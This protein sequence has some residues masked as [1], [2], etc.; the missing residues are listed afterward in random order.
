MKTIHFSMEII[1]N[2]TYLDSL[3]FSD[4]TLECISPYNMQYFLLDS[5]KEHYRLLK[6][7]GSH[8]NFGISD[9]GTNR[10]AS[11]LALGDSGAFVTSYDIENCIE[12]TINMP[13]IQFLIGDIS[14][15]SDFLSAV[16]A[17]E[18]IFLD[19]SHNGDDE[20]QMVSKILSA[21]FS[22]LIFCDDIHVNDDMRRFWNSISLPK[23]DVTKY[24]HITGTGVIDVNSGVRLNLQ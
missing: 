16:S 22:G 19:I 23:Y 6:H 5:G 9:I 10:G 1:L 18:I 13:N 15:R 24:G 11:A 7:I 8:Y 12:T 3:T 17:S 14:S 2:N 4:K 20:I 21:G